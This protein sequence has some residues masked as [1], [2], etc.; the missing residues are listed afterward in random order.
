MYAVARAASARGCLNNHHA[1]S[2]KNVATVAA[3]FG[4]ANVAKPSSSYH[5]LGSVV[6]AVAARNSDFVL[7]SVRIGHP[8]YLFCGNV[9]LLR[10]VI[11]GTSVICYGAEIK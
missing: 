2:A 10:Q 11:H 4:F 5:P 7:L 9:E 8:L 1:F 3:N 6:G